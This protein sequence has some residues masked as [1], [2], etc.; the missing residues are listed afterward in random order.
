VLLSSY[1]SATN[2]TYFS[3]YISGIDY[4]IEP[5]KTITFTVAGTTLTAEE[6]M[7]WSEWIASSYNPILETT[8]SKRFVSTTDKYGSPCIYDYGL[9]GILGYSSGGR[10]SINDKVRTEMEYT[11]SSF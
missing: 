11:K 4:E 1:L 10:V 9:P 2:W 7:T 8:G 3:S 5:L 6:D